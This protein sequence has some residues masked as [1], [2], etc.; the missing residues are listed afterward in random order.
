MRFHPHH[1]DNIILLRDRTVAFRKSS[2]ADGIVFS[3]RPLW[4]NELFMLEIDRNENGWSGHVRLGL[5]TVDPNTQPRLPHYALPDMNASGRAWVYAITR[6]RQR[7][8]DGLNGELVLP[9]TR[10]PL[11]SYS[12][13][14]ETQNDIQ[15]GA[16]SSA[17][18]GETSRVNGTESFLNGAGHV[19]STAAA[20]RPSLSNDGIRLPTDVGS[21]IGVYYRLAPDGTAEMHYVING[22]DQGPS[23][24]GIP[25]NGREGPRLYALVDVYG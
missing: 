4:P 19:S 13:N 10:V 23:A 14:S 9:L 20:G 17:A 7:V 24:V 5:T 18:Y 12:V 6:H 3:A 2:F 11:F 25:Y 22:V 1:G 8:Y 15:L 16:S 21:Q